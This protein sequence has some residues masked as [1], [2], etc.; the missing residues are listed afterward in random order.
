M[1]VYQGES[2]LTADNIFLGQLHVPVPPKPAGE[3][4]VSVRFTYD[5]DGL[6]EA[7]MTVQE[8]GE[9]HQLLIEE[10][11][12]VLTPEQVQERLKELQK[13]KIHPRELLVNAAL[14]ARADRM[15]QQT[16]GDDRLYVGQ[17]TAR[18]QAALETQDEAIIKPAREELKRA[19]DEIEGETWL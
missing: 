3:V 12:G 14:M 4:S 11:P 8:T 5:V 16:R 6:L 2:R 17:E 15:Y 19:L 1:R 13:L 9:K 7:E 10:N 18:F